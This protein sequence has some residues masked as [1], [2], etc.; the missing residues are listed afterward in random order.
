MEESVVESSEILLQLGDVR[1][2]MPNCRPELGHFLAE[3]DYELERVARLLH[4]QSVS[5]VAA[6]RLVAEMATT[7]EDH[8]SPRRPHRLG[9]LVVAL[10]AAGLD[11]RGHALL[12]RG[13]RTVSEREERV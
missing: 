12:E 1:G 8:G 3:A 7:C 2:H 11:D 9:H 6:T 10:R 4:E 5:P 13:L